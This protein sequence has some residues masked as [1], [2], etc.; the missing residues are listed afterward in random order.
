[1][2]INVDQLLI[3]L[4]FLVV[5]IFFISLLCC[6][7]YCDEPNRAEELLED[8]EPSEYEAIYGDNDSDPLANRNLNRD[9]ILNNAFMPDR[10]PH[11]VQNSDELIDINYYLNEKNSTYPQVTITP[12]NSQPTSLFDSSHLMP[13]GKWQSNRYYLQHKKISEAIN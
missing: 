12:K 9:Q 13:F 11:H 3:I 5:M 8:E 4:P 1:M 6:M 2:E 7:I 10:K